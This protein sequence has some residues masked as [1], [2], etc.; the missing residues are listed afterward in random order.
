MRGS[1]MRVSGALLAA[2]VLVLGMT[3]AGETPSEP[4]KTPVVVTYYYLPG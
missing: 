3:W 2:L 1:A 4:A